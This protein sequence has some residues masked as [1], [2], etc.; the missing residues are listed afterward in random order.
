MLYS[1]N[2]E[3]YCLFFDNVDIARRKH[4]LYNTVRWYDQKNMR[5]VIYGKQTEY[6]QACYKDKS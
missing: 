6:T 4:I 2:I 3:K 5:G 1:G